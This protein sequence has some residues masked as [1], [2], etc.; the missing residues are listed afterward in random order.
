[1]TI[2]AASSENVAADYYAMAEAL[3]ALLA[4]NS[5]HVF[6]GAGNFGLMKAV[7]D[8][9][10]K[11]NGHIT[12]II[13]EVLKN[14]YPSVVDSRL[15]TDPIARQR[16]ILAVDIERRKDLLMAESEVMIALP[17][18]L[19]TFEEIY[20]ALA[21]GKRVIILNHAGYYDHLL[22]QHDTFSF[23]SANTPEDILNYLNADHCLSGVALDVAVATPIKQSMEEICTSL[24]NNSAMHAIC[25]ESYAFV[26]VMTSEQKA[27]YMQSTAEHH[28]VSIS[29]R[30][31]LAAE[32]IIL[33][34]HDHP[35]MYA[36]LHKM[37]TYN[38]LGLH[39]IVDN[40]LIHKRILVLTAENQFLQPTYLQFKRAEQERL[41]TSD[42]LI[43]L[44]PVK[45]LN[46][47]CASIQSV[48]LNITE[49]VWWRRPE[50]AI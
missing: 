13:P 33:F 14:N 8:G 18:G 48:P 2:F 46:E 50:L 35:K 30:L 42:H 49:T 40:K 28:P 34:E 22:A 16:L 1:M 36:T 31:F 39:G 21:K 4:A 23:I 43:G 26:A 38:Q 7:A 6:Y 32:H 27:N 44:T 17:G 9:V 10:I 11:N 47:I 41:L 24:N 29:E 12:G 3:G 20:G 15:K 37:L 25:E 45:D 5:Y 19:G